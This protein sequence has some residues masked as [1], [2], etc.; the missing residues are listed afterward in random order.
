MPFGRKLTL[1]VLSKKKT[2]SEDVDAS[3]HQLQLTLWK[4]GVTEEEFREFGK[5]KIR[6][7]NIENNTRTNVNL[8]SDG[9]VVAVICIVTKFETRSKIVCKILVFFFLG[10]KIIIFFF[11]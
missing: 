6:L 7:D 8:K 11:F 10:E 2:F 4:K 3:K 1:Y 5:E 9:K